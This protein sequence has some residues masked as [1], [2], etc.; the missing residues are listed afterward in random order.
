MFHVCDTFDVQ[1]VKVFQQEIQAEQQTD[2]YSSATKKEEDSKLEEG[3]PLSKLGG[4]LRQ[5]SI[6]NFVRSEICYEFSRQKL[7][8]DH[9]ALMQVQE[10]RKREAEAL[11]S[12]KKPNE[13]MFMQQLSMFVK[14]EN[15]E[16]ER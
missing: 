10:T 13:E 11:G 12:S 4:D 8:D 16:I 5:H 15:K 6:L 1:V 7:E 3:D 2:L 14:G 9:K